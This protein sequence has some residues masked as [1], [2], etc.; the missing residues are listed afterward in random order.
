[1]VALAVQ[2]A[3]HGGQESD[4]LGVVALLELARRAVELVDQARPGIPTR[5]RGEVLPML[6][7]LLAGRQRLELQGPEQGLAALANEERRGGFAHGG[8]SSRRRERRRVGAVRWQ[9]RYRLLQSDDSR[10]CVSR[11]CSRIAGFS[12]V[13]TSCVISSP[14]A[15]ERSSRRMILPERVLGRLSPKR[16]SFGLAIAPISLPTQSRSSF[17]ILCASSPLGRAPLSTTNAQT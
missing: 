1:G 4:E 13:D 9:T 3:L 17:A 10:Y 16:M 5:Q 7:D 8:V 15:M 6:L 14:R 2:E 12:R 11:S